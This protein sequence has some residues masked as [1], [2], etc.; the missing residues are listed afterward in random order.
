[1]YLRLDEVVYHQAESDS[2]LPGFSSVLVNGASL[3]TLILSGAIGMPCSSSREEPAG[4][5]RGFDYTG[6]ADEV[7]DFWNKERGNKVGKQREEEKGRS[8]VD[9]YDEK[10]NGLVGYQSRYKYYVRWW[11]VV[12]V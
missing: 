1:M 2:V 11:S 4:G 12:V 3:N 5:K 9:W 6:R 10:L 8:V 7:A